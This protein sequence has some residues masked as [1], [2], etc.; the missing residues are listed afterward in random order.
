[1]IL[2]NKVHKKLKLFKHEF[3]KKC[4]PKLLFLIKKIIR[5]I[6]NI[7]DTENS[8]CKSDFG[9]LSNCQ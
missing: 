9:T 6:R 7:S 5:K 8:L 1:M 3:N 2:V 4:A